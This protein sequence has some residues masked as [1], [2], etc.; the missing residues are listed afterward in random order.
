MT[1]IFGVLEAIGRYHGMVIEI[2]F[3]LLALV[4]IPD[5]R[6]TRKSEDFIKGVLKVQIKV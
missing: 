1:M 4:S 5:V 3:L 6:C 2:H